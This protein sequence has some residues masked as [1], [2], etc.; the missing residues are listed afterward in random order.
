M[1]LCLQ[2]REDHLI[3]TISSADRHTHTFLLAYLASLACPTQSVTLLPFPN[4]RQV[5]H[6]EEYTRVCLAGVF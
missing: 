3:K 1:T 4:P 5:R 2:C 6:A